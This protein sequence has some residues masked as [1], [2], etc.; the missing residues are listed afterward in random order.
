MNR[1]HR[2]WW[3]IF[4]LCAATIALVLAW[5]SA[6]VLAL[7]RAG[8]DETQHQSALR[9]ALWRMDS[10]L[11]PLLSREAARPYFDYQS[12]YPREIDFAHLTHVAVP[13]QVL[14]PSP[15]LIAASEFVRLHFQ[16]DEHRTLTSPQLPD[17]EQRAAAVLGCL[18][19]ATLPLRAQ[20]L[21]DVRGLVQVDEVMRQLDQAEQN[22]RDVSVAQSLP[23][24]VV[25][26]S[27]S[28]Q[29]EAE[30][31][32]RAL[33][34]YQAQKAAQ[35]EAND[36]NRAPIAPLTALTIGPLVTLWLGPARD[37]LFG[38]R[39]VGIGGGLALQGIYFDWPTLRAA[40]LHEAEGLVA[41]ARL[42]PLS[43]PAASDELTMAAIPAR[44]YGEL[45]AVDR[46]VTLTA[47]KIT[48]GVAWLV[49]LGALAAG[50]ITLR[51]SIVFG[52]RRSRF[53][54]AVTHELRTP[55]TTFRLYSEMLADHMVED[56]A[57]RQLYLETLKAESDRLATLVENVL[58]YARVEEGRA[59]VRKT[60]MR[61]DAL[62]ERVMPML[63]Q[64]ATGAGMRLDVRADAAAPATVHVDVDAVAQILFNL[65]DNACKYA[66]GAADPRIEL[67]AEAS[68]GRI[69]FGVADHGPGV[70]AELAS[71][72]FAPFERGERN[73]DP[74]PG[75]G[76]GLALARSLA[77]ELGGDLELLRGD[78]GGA[79]F[80][81]EL[82][83]A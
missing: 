20:L 18:P 34:V 23:P 69:V 53:A 19:A 65:V 63:L 50:C 7:E 14:Q 70:P 62:L 6:T 72:I 46:S 15:L 40:L 32:M 13:G 73:G 9:L 25:A 22:E 29:N 74:T 61:V 21:E 27:Q 2:T 83:A 10:L 41:N 49:V 38:F 48:L 45:L 71:K 12:Y 58:S 59:V 43:S 37:Q 52:E 79:R 67:S 28:A 35:A 80:V 26:G 33:T 78:G 55:L 57:K 81:L 76:L 30:R 77:R 1:S 47:A 56:P 68:R 17:G 44:L 36:A 82:P 39:R 8:R 24:L 42:E 54:S 16:F 66:A 3:L 75:V 51:Q 60:I 4:G 31:N 5:V 11:L 64:R